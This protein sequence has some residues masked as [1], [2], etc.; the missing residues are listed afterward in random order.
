[1][2]GQRAIAIVGAAGRFPGASSIDALWENVVA[3]ADA[4]REIPP[5]RW[6]VARAD[7]LDASGAPDHL[8]STRACLLDE[9]ALDLGG[10]PVP[11]G[12]EALDPVHRLALQ[13]GVDAW[14]DATGTADPGERIDRSRVSVLL[15]NIA[16]PTD[17]S[18][19]MSEAVLGGTSFGR[20]G[21]PGSLGASPVDKNPNAA[22]AALLARVLG[23]GGGSFTL[24]AACASSLY[25]IHL[26]CADLESGRVDAVL[27]GGV[28]RPQ[29]LYTQLGFSQLKALSPSGRCAPFDTRADGLVVGE[30]AGIFLLKRLEDAIAAGDRILGVVRAV[31]LSN[32]VGGSLLSPDTEGQLR[33][34]RA[35]YDAAGWAPSDVDFVECHGTGTPRGDAVELES[36]RTLW[37]DAP[38]GVRAAIGSVKS[39]VGHL[40]TAAGAA[41]LAKVLRAMQART[42]PPSAHVTPETAVAALRDG[43]LRV[44]TA[45][46]PWSEREPG[47]ARRAAISGF[48]FG[49]INA[50]LLLEEFRPEPARAPRV[51]RRTPPTPDAPIAIVGMAAR[52]GRLDGLE[53]FQHAVLR[54]EPLR[55]PLPE[56]R[57]HGIR[58]DRRIPGG[59][60]ERLDVPVGRFKIPPK[61]IPS[62]L[63]QQLLMLQVA[64]DALADT[65]STPLAS[66]AANPRAGAVIG[67]GL[68][69]E[70]NAFHLRW[71]MAERARAEA[72]AEPDAEWVGA[73]RDASGPPLDAQ[74]TLG[75]LGG[76]VASRIAR[77]LSLGAPCFTVAG[78]ETSG[79]RALDVAAG[80]L[81]RGEADVMI[82]GAVDLAGDVRTV[83]ATDRLRPF[84]R[85]GNARP[86]DREADGPLP[87]EGAGAVVLKRLADAERDGDRI[88]AVLRGVGSG[89]SVRDAME[90]AY[91]EAGV[92]PSTVSLLEAHG[93]GARHEDAVESDAFRAV[94]PASAEPTCAIGS[95]AAVVGQSGAATGMAAL[96]KAS[97]CLFQEILPPLPGFREPS[98]DW[99]GTPFHMPVE[100]QVWLRDRASG[101]RRAAVNTLGLDGTCV[102][103][104][105]EGVDRPATHH[106]AERSRP[107]GDRGSAIFLLGDGEAAALRALALA[108]P[109]N[110]IESLAAA[111]F[112]REG[113]R[114]P[115]TR[116]IVASDAAD[117]VRQHDAPSARKSV[118]GGEVAFVF[119]GSGSHYIGMGRSLGAALPRVYRRQDTES[120]HLRSQ[121]VPALVAPWR[122][123]WAPGWEE[124]AARRLAS[125]PERMILGHVAHG[126]AVSD[127][128]RLLGVK[129]HAWIGYSLGES[130]GLFASRAWA[131]R[132]RMF[133]RTLASPL[134]RTQL[135]GPREVA[136]EAWGDA[137]DWHVVVVNRAAAEVRGALTG[138]AA[139]L[140][141]NAPVECVV[142]GKRADVERVVGSLGCE[143][144]PLAGVPTVHFPLVEKVAADYHALH[145]LPTT[146]LTGT[147]YY[148]GA[149]AKPYEPGETS[150]A[151]SILANAVHGFDFTTVIERAYA[152]G[153]RVFLEMGP[154][155][156]CARMIG[157]I[158]GARP[159][160][161]IAA[162]QRGVDGFRAVLQTVAAAAEAGVPVDLAA[163]YGDAGGIRLEGRSR[164]A[165]VVS[166]LVG[167][168]APKRVPMPHRES[169]TPASVSLRAP[170]P[171]RAAPMSATPSPSGAAVSRAS[172][173]ISV[174]AR[175]AAGAGFEEALLARRILETSRST[176][177]AHETFLR[178]AA[179]S[180]A[181]QTQA[182]LAQQELIAGL[183]V[184][185]PSPGANG[186]IRPRPFLDREQCMEF[187]IGRIGKAL[188]PDFAAID[189]HPTRVRLP[190]EP[191]MLVDRIVSVT[192]TPRSLESG[193][194]VTEHDVLP[195][196][197][198]LDG[199]RA[200]VCISVEAGQADLFLSAWLGIDEQTKGLRVYRLLDAKIVFH[201]D[202]PVPGETIRYDIG[203]DRFIR[204]GDTWLFFFRFDGYIGNEPFITMYDG[205]AGFFSEEQLAGG[206]GIVAE[207]PGPKPARRTLPDGT[208]AAPFEPLVAMAK[209]SYTD[210]QLARLRE[211]DAAGCFGPLFDGVTLPA[212]LRLPSGRMQLVDR[213]L[214][215]DPQG[216]RYGLGTVF[217]EADVAPDDWYLTCHFSDD[218]VM[219][220]TLMYECC[221]HTLRVLLLRMGWISPDDA[222]DVHYAPI[223]GVASRLRCR[224]QVLPS[225]S[226]V[227]YRVDIKEIG[228]D[229]EPYVIADASM[230]ADG[231]HVV[232]MESMSV[233]L[234]GVDAER[235]AEAWRNARAKASVRASV[236]AERGATAPS[237][238]V[239]AAP[240]YSKEQ[241]LAYAIGNP[242]E[243]FGEKYRPFDAER[244]LARLPGPPYLFVDRV[245][246]VEPEPWVLKAGGGWVECEYD[247]P[248]DAWYFSA[249]RQPVM[250]FAVLLEAALQPCGWLAAYLGS[251]L[252]SDED[253]H[254]RNLDGH[255]TAFAEIRPDAGAITMRARLTK[256][257][258]AGGMIL[259]KF[260]LEI[261]QAGKKVYAGNTDFGFFPAAAL[262]QQVG[263][264]GAKLP[265]PGKP[266]RAFE[267]PRL[268][269]LFPVDA[270]APRH[271]GLEL[272]GRALAMIDRVEE[273]SL[274]G[275]TNGNGFIAGRKRV[276]PSEWF[277]D[278]HF[279]QD[280]VMPG[281][282]GLEAF[283][284]LLKVWAIERY[285][286]LAKTH[287][288]QSMALDHEHRWQ[289]R[290]QV[291]RT[292][293]ETRVV[294]SI[295][296]VEEGSE[297]LIVAD[298]FL[299]VDG[300]I[301]YQMKDFAIR[302]VRA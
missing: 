127:A 108:P 279:Y 295:S 232:E 110:G 243:G 272:P 179:G 139:L 249:D 281:S 171:P 167:G 297:P 300:R 119:P 98:S 72:G 236:R 111:W 39:N 4:S 151:D 191:L 234:C 16:L 89:T 67:L 92:A 252:T 104:V 138:T 245:M 196:A 214:E 87:G 187:A 204:Q 174:P 203:I 62:V 263:I 123:S 258:Q 170:A 52:Y 129:P 199:G 28:S 190:D 65:R 21:L 88:Y 282:L 47:R 176:G 235:V 275:G 278:A 56:T 20:N 230:Y 211:G 184:S 157:K 293:E 155:G 106:A 202:L 269:P 1:M 296:R 130:A 2:S 255:C 13:T 271:A 80:V 83:L 233:R 101:P 261:L 207:P 50:H 298:G 289:Y 14:R 201:R 238:S 46:E 51:P 69:P 264:R 41:G 38:A 150:C 122:A 181:L 31:G 208:P 30:G 112:R 177:A 132:D 3:R 260:D 273:L 71:R 195:G 222:A 162:C 276:D 109:P 145:R 206:R 58:P 280:P 242:S 165:S 75:A 173:A 93:S 262:A 105:L 219:P 270:P 63:P 161:A 59:W 287:R 136:A 68:D 213:I 250:P 164:P 248:P 168:A 107:L 197:W 247:V 103:A 253:L 99:S 22:P 29:A 53:A 228:Y 61:E 229:P 48:G 137:S 11:A 113:A 212:A 40:L 158:L 78:E 54:G 159:H 131:D 34:M 70:T 246:S 143:A 55:D 294:A 9:F 37:R 114:A 128:V 23:L 5:R 231:R 96:I 85:S 91:A 267:L 76:I 147:R 286:H 32:D 224:G 43:P 141:V 200:P 44:L 102:H 45:A 73:M 126:I 24:D 18:S 25:A 77:E 189:A 133:A 186:E 292:N 152:D 118:T 146:P 26:A 74:R 153:V 81:R 154:Q 182:L 301:I 185:A 84:S 7:V 223:E 239:T 116:A 60:I 121:L 27:A 284:Q 188:G 217:G 166:V 12:V 100:P 220:G 288:F 302:L 299:T 79:L 124:D 10:L 192:G 218:P 193:R 160:V 57:W 140:I 241:I 251:A 144:L 259:Q 134:F 97:L 225:T 163:L 290:G 82:A 178:Y 209:E 268:A 49:G 210:S 64:A 240:V 120:Q 17:A 183:D 90:R 256:T 135:C 227:H 215:I 66:D 115:V 86:F 205:C 36:L 175:E 226:Q 42:L 95:A 194:V 180:L 221:L 117:L 149:W 8:Y 19:A 244:R 257:S 156:S 15:A 198:Y 274:D 35:A 266:G 277:F 283:L 254:F 33:A 291:L 172:A 94:F 6:P 237:R 125:S 148:S 169:Q 142:G 216:G 265:E 285:P